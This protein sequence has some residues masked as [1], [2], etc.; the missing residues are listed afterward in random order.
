MTDSFIINWLYFAEILDKLD[1]R[2]SFLMAWE[3]ECV[4]V[5]GMIDRLCQ[6]IS[7]I[8]RIQNERRRL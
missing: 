6:R 2:L 1:E 5:P 3:P 8:E 4:D 7:T